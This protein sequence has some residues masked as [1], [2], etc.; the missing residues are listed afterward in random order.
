[1]RQAVPMDLFETLM[2]VSNKPFD[3]KPLMPDLWA[4][5][6]LDRFLINWIYLDPVFNW[7]FNPS[8]SQAMRESVNYR[9]LDYSLTLRTCA[10]IAL[11]QSLQTKQTFVEHSY[12]PRYTAKWFALFSHNSQGYT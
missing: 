11:L 6:K 1:M 4:I 12:E 5:N 2:H 9:Y 8:R 3:P 10:C 7:F